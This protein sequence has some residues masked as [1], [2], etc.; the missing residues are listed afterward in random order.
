MVSSLISRRIIGAL[1][2]LRRTTYIQNFYQNILFQCPL[3]WNIFHYANQTLS[4][5]TKFDPKL[6]SLLFNIREN[7]ESSGFSAAEKLAE[8]YGLDT[9][10]VSALSVL[11][12]QLLHVEKSFEELKALFNE[13]TYN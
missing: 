2:P 6:R 12:G 11:A 3:G 7:I 10:N 13:G 1:Y 9:Q 8:A 5:S 4:S